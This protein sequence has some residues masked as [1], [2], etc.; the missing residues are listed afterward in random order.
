MEYYFITGSSRGIG[1]ALVTALLEKKGVH[2]TGISRN[3]TLVHSAY[4]HVSMDLADVESV[5]AYRFPEYTDATR[6]VLVNNAATLEEVKHLGHLAPQTIIREYTI[7]LIA[8]ALLMN[9]FIHTYQ[10]YTCRKLIINI[11]SG[12]AQNPYDGWAVYCSSKAGLDMLTRVAAT[13]QASGK[14][15]PI[16]VRAIAPG[17]VET[18]MQEKLRQADAEHFSAKQKFIDLYVQQKLYDPRDVATR[19]MQIM[20]HPE[21]VRDIVSRIVL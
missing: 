10:D 15:H 7:N 6:L 3:N 1:K 2:I 14:R 11:T 13:E 21:H 9:A 17:V 18:A 12:A 19:L 16:N 8:P 20:E 4:N 5:A